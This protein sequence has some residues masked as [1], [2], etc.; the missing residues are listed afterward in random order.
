MIGQWRMA[1]LADSGVA[2]QSLELRFA[3]RKQDVA[4]DFRPA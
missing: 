2:A 4:T 1:S 3:A